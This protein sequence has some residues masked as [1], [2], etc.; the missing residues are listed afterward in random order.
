MSDS[1]SRKPVKIPHDP[2][3]EAVAGFLALDV[4]ALTA[5]GFG[6][7][8]GLLVLRILGLFIAIL[9]IPYLKYN[10]R[11]AS[12]TVHPYLAYGSFFFLGI[13]HFWLAFYGGNILY[14]ILFN[15][16]A[17]VGFVGFFMLGGAIKGLPKL[18]KEYITL[19]LLGGLALVVIV[20]TIYSL[21]R[22]G[23]FYAAIY[24]GQV[25]YY[26]GVVFPVASEGKFL[27]GF[28]FRE[29]S[30]SYA[31][32]PS[33]L[34]ACSGVGLF[35]L[36]PKDGWRFYALLGFAGVGI[37]SLALV[38]YFMGLILLI[39]VYLTFLIHYIFLRVMPG[40]KNKAKRRKIA[41]VIFLVLVVLAAL[42]V[43][44]LI[45]DTF[46]GENGPLKKIP[47]FYLDGSPRRLGSYI[48]SIE[49]A[50][51]AAMFKTSGGVRTVDYGTLLFGAAPSEVTL[52]AI[53][54]PIFEFSVFYQNGFVG[55]A[56][57]MILI[58]FG[59]YHGWHFIEDDDDLVC[60]KMALVGVLLGVFI[61]FSFVND[62]NPLLHAYHLDEMF[63]YHNSI[64]T[65][66]TRSGY[67]LLAVFL[68]GYVYTP[69]KLPEAEIA[70]ESAPIS[71]IEEKKEAT[72]E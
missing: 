18:K 72:H 10:L 65:P 54:Q 50:L 37:L 59:L 19:A 71:E 34:L 35:A 20:T 46:M 36:R 64:L 22:Y 14:A 11:N 68:L 30:L 47:L 4:L 55:F 6:G 40:E 61:Y 28:L 51:S 67:A 9:L 58:F 15:L 48:D 57:L 41:K 25:Y 16:L 12:H 39:P 66:F 60:R 23:F 2:K 24:K 33:F 69:K 52:S 53:N 42:L 62:E 21:S 70:A 8:T 17:V 44:L 13:S 56:G 26:D 1:S 63:S 5:F 29:T 27:D 31:M 7:Y 32:A 3:L 43:I 45:A 38:P 49:S